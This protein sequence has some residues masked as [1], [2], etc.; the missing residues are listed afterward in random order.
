MIMRA[1]AIEAGHERTYLKCA[2]SAMVAKG[3]MPILE[4]LVRKNLSGWKKEVSLVILRMKCTEVEEGPVEPVALEVM[5]MVQVVKVAE[6]EADLGTIAVGIEVIVEVAVLDTGARS[7]M[8]QKCLISL[9]VQLIRWLP[10]IS[11]YGTKQVISSSNFTALTL[12]FF[13]VI[14]RLGPKL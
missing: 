9:K 5:D 14:E 8:L 4:S 10:I 6:V 3:E 2:G 13:I 7:A 11:N 12:A 1:E